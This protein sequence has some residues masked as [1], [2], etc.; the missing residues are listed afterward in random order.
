[1]V[2]VPP[3]MGG[4]VRLQS[5]RIALQKGLDCVIKD[6]KGNGKDLLYQGI[7]HGSVKPANRCPMEEVFSSNFVM[8]FIHHVGS[9]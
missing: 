7:S 5:E 4:Y 2:P 8:G 9:I 1:M 6:C 3:L